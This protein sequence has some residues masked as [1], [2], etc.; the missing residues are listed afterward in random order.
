MTSNSC[1]SSGRATPLRLK[2]SLQRSS[3]DRLAGGAEV[4]RAVVGVGDGGAEDLGERDGLA[5]A[6][7]AVDVAGE[8]ALG[9]PG[10]GGVAAEGGD[11]QDGRGDQRRRDPPPPRRRGSRR[12]GRRGLPWATRTRDRWPGPR[13]PAQRGSRRRN[14]GPTRVGR[15]GIA[16]S[17]DMNLCRRRGTMSTGST[18]TGGDGGRRIPLPGRPQIRQCYTR[19]PATG[20]HDLAQVF[21]GPA[22]RKTGVPPANGVT[23]D[24]VIRDKPGDQGR[25]AV[26]WAP[27][28]ASGASGSGSGAS[29][30]TRS[31]SS[32]SGSSGGGLGWRSRSITWSDSRSFSFFDLA[33][34]SA[35][36]RRRR[37]SPRRGRPAGGPRR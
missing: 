11:E 12:Q 29:S 23:P 27:R 19:R 7:E 22:G 28:S 4:D 24:R 14:V 31:D 2:N 10:P 32:R 3:V 30:G 15:G 18:R 33:D 37:R 13:R 20:E 1:S 35:G 8:A 9:V 36:P 16:G 25:R 17:C 5:L 26:R 6:A 21:G 34:R